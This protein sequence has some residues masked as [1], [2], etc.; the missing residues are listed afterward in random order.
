[1]GNRVEKDQKKRSK[2]GLNLKTRSL[3]VKE[4]SMCWPDSLVRVKLVFCSV[5]AE[6]PD[7]SY[8]SLQEQE[9]DI[10]AESR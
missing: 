6:A 8:R 4:T 5:I 3:N 2:F 10:P 9:P 7:P 1:M